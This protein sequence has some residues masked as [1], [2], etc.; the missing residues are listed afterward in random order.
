MC[1]PLNGRHCCARPTGERREPMSRHAAPAH[2]DSGR[3]HLK[4][5]G[6]AAGET[7]EGEALGASAQSAE[8]FAPQGLPS[9]ASSDCLRLCDDARR[10]Q[11][12][13]CQAYIYVIQ[14]VDYAFPI[15]LYITNKILKKMFLKKF[16]IFCETLTDV[17]LF[18]SACLF[19]LVNEQCHEMR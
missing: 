4:A 7:A 3:R 18:P 19:S 13:G 15:S 16:L 9:P 1:L 5:K 14:T 10:F 12:A 2:P 11:T 8:A 17:S 6:F